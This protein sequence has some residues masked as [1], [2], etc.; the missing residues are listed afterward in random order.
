[1]NNLQS[2]KSLDIFSLI[3]Q[4]LK[5]V[6][7][8]IQLIGILIVLCIS[9]I[10]WLFVFPIFVTPDAEVHYNIT[11]YI[12]TYLKLP[13]VGFHDFNNEEAAFLQ[14]PDFNK[15]LLGSG[16]TT[17]NSQSQE[18]AFV[19][20]INNNALKKGFTRYSSFIIYSLYTIY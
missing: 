19:D 9:Y 20:S 16:Q 12:G 14:Y 6:K 17:L 2:K 10:L 13:P 4:L 15:I 3:D 11:S 18:T 8:H 5:F 7:T 1:M